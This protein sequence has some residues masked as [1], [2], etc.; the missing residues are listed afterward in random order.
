MRKHFMTRLGLFPLFVSFFSLPVFAYLPPPSFLI[1]SMVA[2]RTGLKTLRITS[3]VVAIEDGKPTN[4]KFKSVTYYNP[5][6]QTM[7]SQALDE[8]GVELFGVEKKSD[9]LPLAI[10]VIYDPSFSTVLGALKKSDILTT[11]EGATD[12]EDSIGGKSGEVI[13]GQALLRRWNGS[14][15][16]VLAPKVK[17]DSSEAS[18]IWIEKDTFLPL[19][20]QSG[21]QDL[22]FSKYRYSQDLP[23][24]RKISLGNRSGVLILEESILEVLVNGSSDVEPPKVASGYTDAGNLSDQKELIRKY[25][26]ALR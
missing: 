15:A 18:Q 3:Q 22:Q 7:R 13:S 12:S 6:T 14:I 11:T 21:D 2:K 16:W 26:A 24:P 5:R 10:E 8:M 25:Y 19:R 17:A 4:R 23:S 20:I 1:K 9:A